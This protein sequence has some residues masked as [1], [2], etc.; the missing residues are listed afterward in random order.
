[1]RDEDV[2]RL[3]AELAD[4][5]VAA[6][7][8]SEVKFTD[9]ARELYGELYPLLT[10]DQDGLL[11][12]ITSRAEVHV[13]R[14]ALHYAILA[15][16]AAIACDHVEA[17]VA[18][19]DFCNASAEALFGDVIPDPL[20][21]RIR[22]LPAVGP[23]SVTQLYDGLARH[24]KRNELQSALR[25]MKGAGVVVSHEEATGGRPK[26]IFRLAAPNE[27]AKEAKKANEVSVSSDNSLNSHGVDGECPAWR[28]A[29]LG[30]DEENYPTKFRSGDLL[31]QSPEFADNGWHGL[32]ASW[33]VR[34]KTEV[35]SEAA[36]DHVGVGNK[37]TAEDVAPNLPAPPL[38]RP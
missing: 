13:I 2:I 14:L 29:A 26:T 8:L 21:E 15:G 28:N 24:A 27:A 10:A 5:L 11:E 35:A 22:E 3:A 31:T 38:R 19:W 7:K 17:A 12:A 6:K 36:I 23:K 18:V 9:D 4:R 32:K 1:M 30:S 33:A 16:S 34:A 20:E 37:Q 25:R